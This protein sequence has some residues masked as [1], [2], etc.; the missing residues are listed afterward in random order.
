MSEI[1]VISDA[2]TV[3]GV[4]ISVMLNIGTVHEYEPRSVLVS[5]SGWASCSCT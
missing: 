5:G 2:D 4:I 3:M 1:R